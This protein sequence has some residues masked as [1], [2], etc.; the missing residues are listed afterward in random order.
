LLKICS[1]LK[2]NNKVASSFFFFHTPLTFFFQLCLSLNLEDTKLSDGDV[3]PLAT[4]LK[5]NH[6]QGY[7]H[8]R[9]SSFSLSLTNLNLSHNLLGDA[10]AIAL[11]EGCNSTFITFTSHLL[12]ALQSN[13][14]LLRLYL[15]SNAIG[16]EGAIHLSRSLQNN[17]T[18]TVLSLE[19][20]VI[21]GSKGLAI[22]S[23]IAQ[24]VNSEE[25]MVVVFF[26]SFFCLL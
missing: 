1:E 11:S 5:E 7:L 15:S 18:L 6:T 4:A 24:R 10:S 2:A 8:F 13:N 20:N 23:A 19:G 17:T 22:I 21:K 26:F 3:K 25:E 16:N 9:L 12:L 14:S